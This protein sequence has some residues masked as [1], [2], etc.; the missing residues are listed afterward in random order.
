MMD[1]I[2]VNLKN[3]KDYYLKIPVIEDLGL[4]SLLEA[5]R[6]VDYIVNRYPAPY[7]LY[8]S[9]GVDSQAMLWAWH[10]S[11]QDFK[12]V[13]YVY[14]TTMNLHDL[15][16]GMTEFL[17]QNNIKIDIERR[18][19]DL[20]SFYNDTYDWYSQEYRCG[21]P[22]ICAYMYMADDQ[23]DGTIIFSGNG[24]EACESY[25][26]KFY[27]KNEWGLYH[28]GY[29]SNKSIVPFFFAETSSLHF[30][31]SQYCEHKKHKAQIYQDAGYPVVAQDLVPN[32]YNSSRFSGFEEIK[33]YYDRFF[34]QKITPKHLLVRPPDQKSK[35]VYDVLLRNPYEFRYS[36]DKYYIEYVS[37]ADTNINNIY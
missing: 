32:K 17:T 25:R 36:N 21:S 14:N 1:W 10:T 22:H 19:V 9:G 33:D 4:D 15:N 5:H 13:S 24:V 35:R 12:A 27:T 20:L 7:V 28:Y 30:S 29:K 26:G 6:T 16:S 34:S 2:E 31:F 18:N 23:Q 8:L 37:K 11:G 3:K